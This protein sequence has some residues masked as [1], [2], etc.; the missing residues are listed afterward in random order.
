MGKFT[1]FIYEKSIAENMFN[2]F[3]FGI[4]NEELT[5]KSV[6]IKNGTEYR[7]QRTL[8]QYQGTFDLWYAKITQGTLSMKIIRMPNDE[9]LG[10]LSCVMKSDTQEVLITSHFFEK[11]YTTEQSA[12]KG[13]EGML[14]KFC[15]TYPRI[16][17]FF[18][19]EV[20]LPKED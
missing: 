14:P 6:R 10:Q 11:I 8:N 2:R 1:E 3:S 9:Y 15:R 20:Q 19:I 12:L 7:I 13:V 16:V 4:D 18:Y 5:A 17:D